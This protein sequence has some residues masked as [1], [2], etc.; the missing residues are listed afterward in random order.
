MMALLHN[1]R[2][3]DTAV[4][5]A[6]DRLGRSLAEVTG[7]IADLGDRRI[8]LCALGEGVDTG[9]PTGRAVATI[10]ATSASLG[11]GGHVL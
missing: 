7:T 11:R 4:V 3:G 1:V 5:T 9:T 8:L 6:I 10:M 2:E